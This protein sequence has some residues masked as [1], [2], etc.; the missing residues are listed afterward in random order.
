VGKCQLCPTAL[1]WLP[2]LSWLVTENQSNWQRG[3][4]SKDGPVAGEIWVRLVR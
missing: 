2:L 3:L 4:V 1:V